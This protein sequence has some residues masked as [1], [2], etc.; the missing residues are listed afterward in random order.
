MPGLKEASNNMKN[1]IIDTT[2][3]NGCYSCQI[4][5][6]EEHV[7]NEGLP[8]AKPQ[9]DTGQFW[10]KLNE[11]VRGQVPHVKMSYVFVP[12]QHCSDAPC[13]A[14]CNV[15]AIYV[16]DDGLVIINPAKC[17]GCMN[18]VDNCPYGAIFYNEDLNIAQKCTGC[19]HL[20]DKD[21]EYQVPRC[22][23]SCPTGAIK[24]GED[25]DLNTEIAEAETLHPEYDLVTKVHYI[26]LPKRFVAGTLYNSATNEVVVGA[27]CSL[28]GTAG[29]AT[30]VTDNFGD[31]W[32]N[33]LNEGEFT[34]TIVNEGT[35]KVIT[36]DTSAEDIGL[37]YIDITS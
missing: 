16:R 14:A 15:D 3:C 5:C 23:D 22:Y 1:F 13:I 6:K 4:S 8:Y 32:L 7:G 27:T 34:L 28:S 26:G 2:I 25:S 18:C 37:G 19:A 9:P 10:G 30:A 11:Y 24:F 36:G 17:T 31:F 20:L 33:E 35:T 12:C 21:W 29:N